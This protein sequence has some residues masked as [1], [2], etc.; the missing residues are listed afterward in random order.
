VSTLKQNIS[1]KYELL[2]ICIMSLVVVH[3][4]R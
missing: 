2:P 1:V 4:L 3:H